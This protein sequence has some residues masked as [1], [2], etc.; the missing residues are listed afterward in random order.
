MLIDSG[1][2]TGSFSVSGS[3][4]VT[5]NTVITGSINAS[6]D[7]VAYSTSDA[8]FKI[9]INPISD[10]LSKLNQINGVEFDWLEN[11]EYHSFKGHDVGVI[12]QEIEKVLP[13]IVTTKDNGYK[14]VKYEKIIPL[15][16]EA[17]KAQ[18]SQ[19]N[20][21]KEIINKDK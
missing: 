19:I 7:I 6:D 16:I 18:Q 9:N 13:E 2:I 12:A 11:P 20:D 14:A 15:L 3:M 10:S 1:T 17:I 4:R 8:R 5:G 21:L